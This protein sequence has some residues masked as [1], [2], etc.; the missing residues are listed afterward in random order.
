MPDAAS[1]VAR[2]VRPRGAE[3]VWEQLGH[4]TRC[5]DERWRLA[6]CDPLP[7]GL[8]LAAPADAASALADAAGRAISCVGAL[9]PRAGG[10]ARLTVLTSR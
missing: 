9:R 1:L 10:G 8:L 4:K 3:R 5:G 2:G 7:A 6:L